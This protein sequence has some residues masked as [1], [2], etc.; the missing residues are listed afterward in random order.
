MEN[1]EPNPSKAA[2]LPWSRFWTSFHGSLQ[3]RLHLTT[4]LLNRTFAEGIAAP[5]SC[6]SASCSSFEK[7]L[8][9]FKAAPPPVQACQMSCALAAPQLENPQF[10]SA[11]LVREVHSRSWQAAELP[12]SILRASIAGQQNNR[13]SS[14]KFFL[15]PSPATM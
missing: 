12:A 5:D 11:S 3:C 4:S 6:P 7:L 2:D 1:P 15:Q 14:E 10:R 13:S 9:R 8:L